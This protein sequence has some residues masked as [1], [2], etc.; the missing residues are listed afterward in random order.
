MRLGGFA[1]ER[2]NVCLQEDFE[3]TLS[4]DDSESEFVSSVAYPT[5]NLKFEEKV[6]FLTVVFEAEVEDASS[7]STSEKYCWLRDP[8]GRT[9]G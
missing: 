4:F 3:V 8:F 9:I 2:T 5:S 6:D 7:P 1:I